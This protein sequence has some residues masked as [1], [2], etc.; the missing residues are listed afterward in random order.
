MHPNPAFHTA[1]DD[2]NLRFARSVAFGVLSI[3]GTDGPFL[4]HI[5][6]LLSENGAFADL[7]LVRS[8]PMVRHLAEPQSARLAVSGPDGYVSP[9]WYGIPDQ[10]PT[11]NYVAVHLKGRL[12]R[13][14]QDTLPDLLERQ[15]EFFERRLDPKPR[16]TMDKL[17]DEAAA[18]LMRVIV[19]FG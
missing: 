11:W 1:S 16:W 3:N 17:S 10:V 14:P 6:F 7:H 9:D 15:S 2:E 19:P 18:R 8:N 12:E 4:S 13:M 5:P